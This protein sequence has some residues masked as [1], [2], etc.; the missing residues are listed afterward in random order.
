VRVECVTGEPAHTSK[1]L[2]VQADDVGIQVVERVAQMPHKISAWFARSVPIWRHRFIG[3][4]K[5]PN[6]IQ[7]LALREGVT[8]FRDVRETSFAVISGGDLRRAG[9]LRLNARRWQ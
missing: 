3:I 4:A 1:G 6:R 7:L 9:R 2:V 5:P 8:A